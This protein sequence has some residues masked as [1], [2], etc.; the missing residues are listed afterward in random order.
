MIFYF[1]DGKRFK[2]HVFSTHNFEGKLRAS[3]EG[4]LAW[5]KISEIPYDQMWDDDQFWLTLMLRSVKFDAK[6]YFN[7]NGIVDEMTIYRRFD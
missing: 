4:E 1:E 7:E 2:V 5:F 6:V 3:D